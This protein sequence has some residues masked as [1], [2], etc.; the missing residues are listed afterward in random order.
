[1]RALEK[2]GMTLG[3]MSNSGAERRHEYGRRASRK[4]LAS[5]GWRK[6]VPE[7]DKMKNLA[8]YITLK[9]IWM[10]DYGGDLLS[11]E[12]ARL[13]TEGE[14]AGT[15]ALQT[16]GTVEFN[17]K[18]RRALLSEEEVRNEDGAGPLDPPPDFETKNKAVWGVRSNKE[19]AH[20][21]FWVLPE[22]E[23]DVDDEEDVK[24]CKSDETEKR[25]FNPDHRHEFFSHVPV[26]FS[27][28]ESDAGSEECFEF[29]DFTI[30]DVEFEDADD[31]ANEEEYK[32]RSRSE[33]GVREEWV[34]ELPVGGGGS[35]DGL[36]ENADALL[37]PR[38]GFRPKTVE[39]SGLSKEAAARE[40]AATGAGGPG[41]GGCTGLETEEGLEMSGATPPIGVIAGGLSPAAASRAEDSEPIG[42]SPTTAAAGSTRVGMGS[43]QAS[44]G[45]KGSDVRA[46][47]VPRAD[48]G[49][50]GARRN[51]ARG[52][53][54]RRGRGRG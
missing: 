37:K 19:K 33:E 53:G 27:D 17:T 2:E 13:S 38:F 44:G 9:E 11:H 48:S 30:N 7:Y 10:W 5:N 54:G 35:G 42:S 49:A 24:A 20:A 36:S 46:D 51:P 40:A 3:M 12:L 22:E 21:I 1:M 41:G 34:M 28:D 32:P 47:P 8:V 26:D 18:S 43:Q 52:R 50:A 39:L 25:K 15:G 6:K 31:P 4:A 14:S 23:S 29:A 16:K 45:A